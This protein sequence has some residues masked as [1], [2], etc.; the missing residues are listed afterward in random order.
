MCFFI[1]EKIVQ[2]IQR[3]KW[4][5]L[6]DEKM[7]VIIAEKPSVARNIAE[8]LNVKKRC[9]GYLE[10]E[11]YLIT[12]AFG[13]LLQLYDAKDYDEKMKSW[14]LDKFPFMPEQFKYKVKS[15]S[16]NKAQVD[17]GAKKQ[18][19]IICLFINYISSFNYCLFC[20]RF[21]YCCFNF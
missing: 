7:K 18:I 21:R 9:D 8:A 17:A 5:A 14:T 13:H 20:N 3:S 15:D 2:S 12:W 1:R 16:K 6:G 4:I 19:E 10:G 11:G